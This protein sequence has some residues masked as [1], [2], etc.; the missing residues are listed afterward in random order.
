MCI[1]NYKIS[2]QEHSE[3]EEMTE[4]LKSEHDEKIKLLDQ[5]QNGNQTQEELVDKLTQV[6]TIYPSLQ[7]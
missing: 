7:M 5:L 2:L 1:L 3:L 4:K 6:I